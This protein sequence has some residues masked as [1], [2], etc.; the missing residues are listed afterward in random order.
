MSDSDPSPTDSITA[1]V[2]ELLKQP[3]DPALMEAQALLARRIATSSALSA[4][5]IPPPQNITEV[6][7]YL[8]LLEAAGESTMRLQAVAGALGLAGPMDTPYRPGGPDLGFGSLDGLR[9]TSQAQAAAPATIE[10]R[11]DFVGAFSVALT[12]LRDLGLELPVLSTRSALPAYEETVNDS[13]ALMDLVGRRLRIAP[14]TALLDPTTDGVL[15]VNGASSIEVHL[16]RVDDNAPQAGD[17]VP[18]SVDVFTCT[19]TA[20]S[21]AATT[22]RAQPLAPVLAVAGW[23][24]GPR[25]APQS[26]GE[27]GDWTSFFNATGLIAGETTYGDE[28]SRLFSGPQIAASGVRHRVGAVWNGTEFD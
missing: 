27:P 3:D 16:R 4:A 7:G 11:T 2:L 14:S 22:L 20:C 9:T 13:A 21:S 19:D 6:G 17:V 15:I 23:F 12:R 26:L 28:L 5:R 8:N 25:S 10:M 1:T 18:V 24:P